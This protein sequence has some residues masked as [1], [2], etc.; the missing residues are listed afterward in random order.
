VIAGQSTPE[1]AAR[2]AARFPGAFQNRFYRAAQGR[3]VSS[4]GLGTYLGEMSEAAD[5]AYESAI[6]AA[7]RGGINFLDAAINYRNQQSERNIGAAL[8]RL[9]ESG[10]AARDEVVI[11]TKAGFLTPGAIPRDL[12]RA[13]DVAGN[14][15]C[16]APDFLADQI[17]RSRLN[18]GLSTIDVFYLHNPETQL[19]SV[20]QDE[21]DNRVRRAFERLEQLAADGTILFYGTATWN[22]YRLKPG[23]SGRLSLKR[24]VELA[25]SVAGDEHRFRFV[26]LP[27]N[28]AMAEA[29]SH[30][31]DEDQGAPQSVLEVAA[32]AGITVVASASLLQAKLASDLPPALRAKWPEPAD[33][34]QFA[35]Q[36]T[37]STPGVS[38]ALA[39]MGQAEHVAE[40]LRLATFPPAD[41]EQYLSLFQRE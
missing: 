2:Y 29:F 19:G 16:M 33:D 4:L 26:Q 37:R 13:E 18:L 7:V 17:D 20:S 12:V 21:F 27:L 36:F 14:I 9:I 11:C 5:A 1:G 22:G 3:L 32:R 28:L 10:A 8:T 24:M 31:H 40:N 34:A 41:V 15:H 25:K 35:L 39:G 6:E 23:A 38:V 30:P